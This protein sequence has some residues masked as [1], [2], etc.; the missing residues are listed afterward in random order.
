MAEMLAPEW[1]MSRWPSPVT[2]MKAIRTVR[3]TV[4][5]STQTD[6]MSSHPYLAGTKKA[7]GA[8]PNLSMSR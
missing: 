1:L 2:S 7:P 3:G 8:A 4:P 5:T 6:A